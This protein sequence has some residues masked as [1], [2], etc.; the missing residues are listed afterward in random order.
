MAK[1]KHDKFQGLYNDG[2]ISRLEFQQKQNDLDNAQSNLDQA[3]QSSAAADAH[4]KAK[5]K[6]LASDT[7]T[8]QAAQ[9]VLKSDQANLAKLDDDFKK[10]S[11][12]SP[13][14]NSVTL[15]PT[16]MPPILSH[17]VGRFP[18]PRLKAPPASLAPVKIDFQAGKHD[19][20]QTKVQKAQ[21]AVDQIKR[22]LAACQ[23]VALTDGAVSKLNFKSGDAITKN[24]VLLT[25]MKP[26][27]QRVIATFPHDQALR[28]KYGQRCDVEF[29]KFPNQVFAG[30]VASFLDS[31]NA[32]KPAKVEILIPQRSTILSMLPP[33]TAGTVHVHTG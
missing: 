29:R 22:E 28:I 7:N 33:G 10:L 23:V 32:V 2:I 21:A 15:V 11:A 1:E 16:P 9:T 27:S 17:H 8:L 18:M 13:V 12:S 31:G 24:A 30:Q 26:A 3:T 25:L 5:Q 6:S 4:A 19:E 14:Q 20:A